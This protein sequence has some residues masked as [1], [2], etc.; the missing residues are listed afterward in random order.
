LGDLG[1]KFGEQPPNPLI[2]AFQIKTAL[3]NSFFEPISGII[4]YGQKPISRPEPPILAVVF[5]CNETSGQEDKTDKNP[6]GFYWKSE[7]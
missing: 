7:L 2:P 6:G 4:L 1:I 3:H 5:F